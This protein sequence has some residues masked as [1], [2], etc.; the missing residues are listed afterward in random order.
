MG[1]KKH[2]NV[3]WMGKMGEKIKLKSQIVEWGGSV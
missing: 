1:G 2:K 3:V